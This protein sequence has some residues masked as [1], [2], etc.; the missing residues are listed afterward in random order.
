M[1][2]FQMRASYKPT[3][4][5]LKFERQTYRQ[6]NTASICLWDN[7]AYTYRI[8]KNINYDK[9]DQVHY[10]TAYLKTPEAYF[11][12]AIDKI[13]GNCQL[14][15]VD[16]KWCLSFDNFLCEPVSS[17]QYNYSSLWGGPYSELKI[18]ND[19]CV[20][21][22]PPVDLSTACIEGLLQDAADKSATSLD[23]RILAGGVT[24]ATGFTIA[25]CILGCLVG[26]NCCRSKTRSPEQTQRQAEQRQALVFAEQPSAAL[27]QAAANTMFQPK[28]GSAADYAA[29]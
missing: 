25:L 13:P 7:N 6:S 16:P 23:W 2:P 28:A 3:K 12:S 19:R 18:S 10:S 4:A 24:G 29:V 1:K 27:N 5:D 26:H 17:R 22:Y 11:D 8:T 20:Y 15:L 9:Q 21:S 14:K